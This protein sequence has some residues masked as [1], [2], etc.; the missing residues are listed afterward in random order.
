MADAG[1]ASI[2]SVRV[3]RKDLGGAS[4]LADSDLVTIVLS[5]KEKRVSRIPLGNIKSLRLQAGQLM[6]QLTDGKALTL[7]GDNAADIRELIG[8]KCRAIPELTRGLRALGSARR[9]NPRSVTRARSVAV[10]DEQREFFAPLLAARGAATLATTPAASVAAFDA[11]TLAD[12][13]DATIHAFAGARFRTEGP[14]RRALQAEL[15]DLTAALRTALA[16]LG[17]LASQAQA[18]PDDFVRWR[19]WSN[20]LRATFQ[21]ADRAWMDIARALAEYPLEAGA[22]ASVPAR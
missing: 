3:G 14:H 9:A 16:E 12:T 5:S 20:Q 11:R 18:D 19:K 7:V 10:L 15:E 21:A 6:V 1:S 13:I 8:A 4:V 22:S 17:A 2:A